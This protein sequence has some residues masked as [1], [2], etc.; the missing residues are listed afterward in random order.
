MVSYEHPRLL[1]VKEQFEV[2]T[3]SEMLNSALILRG[4]SVTTFL[5][6]LI[7]EKMQI[8]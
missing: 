6:M 1:N 5:L 4:P 2:P 3:V 7:G 8:H